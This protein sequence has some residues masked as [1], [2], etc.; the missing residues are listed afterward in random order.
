MRAVLVARSHTARLWYC[1]DSLN[2][3][4]CRSL[5]Q[6]MIYDK[7]RCLSIGT[8]GIYISTKTSTVCYI[9]DESL[10]FTRFRNVKKERRV[11]ASKC[12]RY[13]YLAYHNFA[14][15]KFH[16]SNLPTLRIPMT[17]DASIEFSLCCSSVCVSW[18]ASANL[19]IFYNII[20]YKCMF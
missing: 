1:P 11:N 20:G 3:Q 16:D 12:F 14:M 6:N 15:A 19:Q 8:A 7:N 17:T 9:L 18:S 13:A 10:K 5:T 4:T 2:E